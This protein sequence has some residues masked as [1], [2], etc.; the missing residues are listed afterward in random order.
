MAKYEESG[1]FSMSA[2][3]IRAVS[4]VLVDGILLTDREIDQIILFL[5]TLEDRS[6]DYADRIV[7]SSVPSGLD[8]VRLKSE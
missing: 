7:P 5:G 1:A 2:D 4:P 8:V 3:Q 6:L